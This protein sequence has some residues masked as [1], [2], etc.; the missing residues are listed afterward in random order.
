MK[1]WITKW[2]LAKGILEG[3]STEPE[4]EGNTVEGNT[5]ECK[6]ATDSRGVVMN[7]MW[8]YLHGEG[9][10]WHRTRQQAV[11]RAEALRVKK[12]KALRNQ[13]AVLV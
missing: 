10:E 3:Q 5:V 11:E 4:G 6:A 12:I 9:R 13:I 8:G 7:F 2:V 1:I